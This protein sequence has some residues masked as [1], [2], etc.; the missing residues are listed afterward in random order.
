MS[1]VRWSGLVLAVVVA[2][3]HVLPPVVLSDGW[4]HYSG[5]FYALIAAGY[6]SFLGYLTWFRRV[7]R[8]AELVAG[9]HPDR[10]SVGALPLLEQ[11]AGDVPDSAPSTAEQRSAA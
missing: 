8:D 1:L 4:P 7:C 2:L 10:S 6:G 5:W 9:E 3:L 11:F